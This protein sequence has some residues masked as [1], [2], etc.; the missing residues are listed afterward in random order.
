MDWLSYMKNSPETIY[1]ARKVKYLPKQ[2]ESPLNVFLSL[3]NNFIFSIN[4]FSPIWFDVPPRKPH[5]EPFISPE[6]WKYRTG[7]IWNP[8]C[9]FSVPQNFKFYTLHFDFPPRERTS[10]HLF[11]LKREISLGEVWKPTHVLINLGKERW[12][13]TRWTSFSPHVKGW[14]KGAD[15]EGGEGRAWRKGGRQGERKGE[16]GKEEVIRERKE[17]VGR[18]GKQAQFELSFITYNRPRFVVV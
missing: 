2:Y 13:K 14:K 3:Q 7:K 18:R 15:W 5:P 8:S 4:N 1:L 12:T 6:P 10:S 17:R 11:C 16:G 9:V